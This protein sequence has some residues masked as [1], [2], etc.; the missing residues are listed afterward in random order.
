[1]NPEQNIQQNQP[2]PNSKTTLCKHCGATIASNA[3]ICPSCGGKNAKPIYKRPWFIAIVVVLG[4][5]VIGSFA[6]SNA[7]KANT[8][9]PG[10]SHSAASTVTSQS[11]SEES[12]VNGISAASEAS[13]VSV[14]SSAPSISYT[15]YTVSKLLDDLETNAMKASN[16]YKGQYVE[17]TGTLNVIDS[18]GKYISLNPENDEFTLIGIQCYIK[19]DD[20]KNAIM[21]MTKGDTLVVKGKIKDV[22]EIM[23]YSLDID[24]IAK[25]Q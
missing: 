21:E 6:G 5:S 25:A 20:Q 10:T 19:S 9:A 4:L 2:S 23:G 8:K 16:D 7:N 15:P 12:G 11:R 3:K 13:A 1:M 14:V 17:L 18:S 22:G 24:E